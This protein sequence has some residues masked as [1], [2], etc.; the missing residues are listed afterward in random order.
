ME[1]KKCNF[2]ITSGDEGDSK[3][4]F[5]FTALTAWYLRMLRKGERLVAN[6]YVRFIGAEKLR[7]KIEENTSDGRVVLAEI[8]EKAVVVAPIAIAGGCAVGREELAK[9]H[10]RR[11]FVCNGRQVELIP[12]YYSM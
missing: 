6:G 8:D 9:P 1:K 12:L 2:E 5:L 4:K 3:L 11:N 7:R 10:L